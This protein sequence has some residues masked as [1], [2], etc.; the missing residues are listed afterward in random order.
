MWK[1]VQNPGPIADVAI[2]NAA[3][4]KV[5][6]LLCFLFP[7]NEY[8]FRIFSTTDAL[9]LSDFLVIFNYIFRFLKIFLKF[10]K[11]RANPLSFSEISRTMM[12][13]C[14]F[15]IVSWVCPYRAGH[16]ISVFLIK[17][18]LHGESRDSQKGRRFLSRCFRRA[19]VPGP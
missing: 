4:I 7:I 19:S 10:S 9:I 11:N 15:S 2:R 14:T 1:S 16:K 12:N 18:S 3:P 17:S 8:P 13:F 6:M 5:V